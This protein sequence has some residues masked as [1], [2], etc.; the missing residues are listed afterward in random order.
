MKLTDKRFWIY[1][2]AT[3]LCMSA[4]SLTFYSDSIFCILLILLSNALA[5]AI[6]LLWPRILAFYTHGFGFGV[7]LLVPILSMLP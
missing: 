6:G 2:I 4:F 7:R 3:A 5:V 1:E